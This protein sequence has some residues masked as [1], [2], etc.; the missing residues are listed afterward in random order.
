[1]TS[2]PPSERICEAIGVFLTK[3]ITDGQDVTNT[4]FLLGAQRLI[5]ELLEQEATDYLGRERYERSG[6]ENKCLRNGY[7]ERNAK[8]AK[9]RF[10]VFLPQ[11]R[12]AEETYASRLWQF[13]K[14]NSNVFR[15]L[16]A[17]M[18]ARGLS[19]RDI[20]ATFTD[21]QGNCLISK[22][23]VSEVTETLW[24]DY[25][26]FSER[27]LSGFEVAYIF[28]DAVYEPMRMFKGRKEGILCAWTILVSGEKVLLH[29][30]LGNKESY[31]CWL[32][33]LRNMV[34]RGLITPVSITSDG[35]PGLKRAIDEIWPLSLRIR[36]WVHKMNNI[37]GKVPDQ[38]KAEVKAFLTVVRDAPNYESGYQRAG[39][40]I[41]RFEK[42]FPRAMS[43]FKGDLEASLAHLYLP[44][45]HRKY[46]RTTNSIERSF[47]E[48]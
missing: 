13:V 30:D 9:G 4:L 25:L 46:V 1:M 48:E 3:G 39:V 29:L 27:D 2:I 38:H 41:N 26:A 44:V 12:G 45:V 35:A 10:P 24:E 6:E 34:S 19:T 32:E 33:F 42:D 20:E 37:L 7:K 23:A 28:L 5:Q 40:L 22:S 21:E 11:V 47:G 8:C 15:Y 36:C 18:N 31:E 17:E 43:S 16:V 14:G